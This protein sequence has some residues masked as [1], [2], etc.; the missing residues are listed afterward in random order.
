MYCQRSESKLNFTYMIESIS[1]VLLRLRQSM[2]GWWLLMVYLTSVI[3]QNCNSES[4]LCAISIC[5]WSLIKYVVTSST[6]E[7]TRQERSHHMLD[8]D[9]VG[10]NGLSPS[11]LFDALAGCQH[12]RE[13]ART[14]LYSRSLHIFDVDDHLAWSR[15]SR[16]WHRTSCTK[17][18]DMPASSHFTL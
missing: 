7:M 9:I 17:G 15:R 1:V 4:A 14:L 6:E 5:I 12:F 16:G 8:F 10:K 13:G 3:G 11:D 2:R 18:N